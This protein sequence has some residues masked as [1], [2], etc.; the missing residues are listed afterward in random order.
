MGAKN[1][2]VET[3]ARR[4]SN[5]LKK[6]GLTGAQ[7]A[8]EMGHSHSYFSTQIATF[9]AISAP[10]ADHLKSKYG[11]LPEEYAPI[12]K[13]EKQETPTENGAA[14]CTDKDAVYMATYTAIMNTW[15]FIRDDLKA[16]IKEALSE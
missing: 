8:Q 12:I 7:A 5:A 13:E 11:I 4:L 15:S 2:R 1:K 16:I 14:K 3:D 9:G 10:T 6:R